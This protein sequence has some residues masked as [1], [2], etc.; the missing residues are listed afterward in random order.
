MHD[1]IQKSHCRDTLFLHMCGHYSLLRRLWAFLQEGFFW[2]REG[3]PTWPVLPHLFLCHLTRVYLQSTKLPCFPVPFWPFYLE[4]KSSPRAC[5][6]GCVMSG[7]RL[8]YYRHSGLAAKEQFLWLGL[9]RVFW[10][11]IL[12]QQCH[13]DGNSFITPRRNSELQHGKI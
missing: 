11:F 3:D 10:G 12:W 4:W 7:I 5:D 13:S 1:W 6:S 2:M 8:N 9:P